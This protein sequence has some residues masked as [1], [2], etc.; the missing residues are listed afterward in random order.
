MA[1]STT[2]GT[3][4][5]SAASATPSRTA[6]PQHQ[7]TALL[8]ELA[9]G[10]VLNVPVNH[11][12]CSA[13]SVLPMH[14]LWLGSALD[15]STSPAG[16]TPTAEMASVGSFRA[17]ALAAGSGGGCMPTAE[18]APLV[19]SYGTWSSRG[20][21]VAINGDRV[22][23]SSAAG[24]PSWAYADAMPSV[25]AALNALVKYEVSLV[26]ATATAA[27]LSDPRS[28]VTVA[29]EQPDNSTAALVG[30]LRL[31]VRYVGDGMRSGLRVRVL[32]PASLVMR[33]VG[34]AAL[35]VVYL[36]QAPPT[37][38]DTEAVADAVGGATSATSGL[39]GS[40]GGVVR[41]GM[42][43]SLS[44]LIRCEPRDLTAEQPL[45]ANPFNIALGR[46]E[47]QYSRGGILS[48]AIVLMCLCVVIC[49]LVVPSKLVGLRRE[50]AAYM[51]TLTDAG[52]EEV[53]PAP[54]WRDAITHTQLPGLLL[55]PMA[56]V[57]ESWVPNGATLVS[58][59]GATA[60]DIALGVFALGGFTA[61]LGHLLATTMR[62]DAV[63]VRPLR[64]EKQR[65]SGI[66]HFVQYWLHSPVLLVPEGLGGGDAEGGGGGE[67]E[68]PSRQ[69]YSELLSYRSVRR[70]L[71]GEE[72]PKLQGSLG[73]FL[74][75]GPYADELNFMWFKSIEVTLGSVVNLMDGVVT[76]SCFVRGFAVL[77][78]VAAVLLI[79]AF[80][81]PLAVPAQQLTTTV[82]YGSMLL[83]ATVVV[84]NLFVHHGSLEDGASVLFLI[85]TSFLVLQSVID[86][87]ISVVAAQAL[88]SAFMSRRRR[89]A[90]D[91]VDDNDQAQVFHHD[92]QPLLADDRLRDLI[93]LDTPPEGNPTPP[94]SLDGSESDVSSKAEDEEFAAAIEE[95]REREIRDA[96][97]ADLEEMDREIAA[98]AKKAT[99]RSGYRV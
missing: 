53:L 27:P 39:T 64:A 12:I 88:V 60:G 72:G 36:L 6:T 71:A 32:I 80:K 8:P 90:V 41:G 34:G 50:H 30:G 31:R 97:L 19:V 87:L 49:G 11:T 74:R 91:V 44:D 9:L 38:T 47:G 26:Y 68:S 51:S 22:A 58:M 5:N 99:R 40:P 29:L 48:G 69:Q 14:A 15:P 92:P 18:S 86:V 79:M 23:A 21:D 84:A 73:W 45:L 61:Y 59:P 17:A 98:A 55:V 70:I 20:V 95:A 85:S 63:R 13:A 89:R 76:S 78:A 7:C 82:V 24:I 83:A 77:V 65:L 75:Y 66:G 54:T 28:A 43:S 3:A 35:E 33:C 67:W 94:L 16:T 2:Q 46:P 42:L 96:I 52:D 81:R 10:G 4:T 37:L 56:L 1:P 25:V 93:D 62:V 57:G